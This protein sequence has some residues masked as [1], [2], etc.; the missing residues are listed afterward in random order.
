MESSDLGNDDKLRLW[1]LYALTGLLCGIAAFIID[2]LVD[3]L[4]HWKW[5]IAQMLIENDTLASAVATFIAFSCLLGGVAALLTVFMGPGAVGSGTTELMA[6]LNGINYPKFFGYRTLFVKIFG[7]CLA[8]S[9]GLCVG[10]E[11]PLAHIGAI[12]G[13]AVVY[14]PLDKLKIFHNAVDKREIACA[15][16]AAG[17][18]AAFGAPIG[19]SLF[20]YEVSR[21]STFWS[22]NL[23]WKIFF[24][25][26]IATFVLNMCTAL[27]SGETVHITNAGLI[28]FGSYI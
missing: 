11:G 1:A 28:K 21:P 8:V 10:K 23:T 6:Y 3:N 26:S 16:A 14:L 27:K 18:S 2:L 13:H 15:G 20:I 12:I 5:N 19:G 22:F 4:V 25:S 17:V 7:L 9:A 24:S